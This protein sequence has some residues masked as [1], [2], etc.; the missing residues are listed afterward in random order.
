MYD[1][2]PSHNNLVLLMKA[3]PEKYL[4]VWYSYAAK[5]FSAKLLTQNK[6]KSRQTYTK[7]IRFSNH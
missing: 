7:L 3:V 5:H 2:E 4:Q 1:T 6:M